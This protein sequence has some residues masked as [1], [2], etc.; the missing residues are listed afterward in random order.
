MAVATFF[1]GAPLK[2]FDDTNPSN[3]FADALYW[4][5]IELFNFPKRTIKQQVK[6]MTRNLMDSQNLSHNS[7]SDWLTKISV[8]GWDNMIQFLKESKAQVV[9]VYGNVSHD[10]FAII[11]TISTTSVYPPE[12]NVVNHWITSVGQIETDQKIIADWNKE[13][14]Q[15]CAFFGLDLR[16]EPSWMI[17]VYS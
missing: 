9:N 3:K 7:I 8:S 1:Y 6:N 5:D 17:A 14:M 12:E 11:I 16:E 10:G 4:L 2:G 13:I 15:F